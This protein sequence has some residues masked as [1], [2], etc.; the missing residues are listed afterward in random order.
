MKTFRKIVET[1]LSLQYHDTLNDKLW[2]GLELEHDIRE[3]LLAIGYMFAEYCHIPKSQVLD[4]ILTGGNA[5]YNYTRQSDIDVH[6]VFSKEA[7]GWGAGNIKDFVDDYLMDKKSLWS[8]KHGIT[9]HGYPIELYAQDASE[10]YPSNQG[11]YSLLHNTWVQL[12]TRQQ[13]SFDDPLLKKKV[14]SYKHQ[15]DSM[16]KNNA[17]VQAFKDLRTRLKDMRSAA[18]AQGGEFSF[19]NLVFKELRN[20]GYLDRINKHVKQLTDKELSL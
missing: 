11:V 19:E 8:T 4:V 9:I 3:R 10:P 20:R 5:N 14:M 2:N 17:D 7:L 15:I 12:P 6:V 13:I 18:I 16:I 1:K